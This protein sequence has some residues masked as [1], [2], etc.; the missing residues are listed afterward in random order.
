MTGCGEERAAARTP[1]V[2]RLARYLWPYRIPFAIALVQVLLLSGFEL[3]KPWPLKVVV[4]SVLGSL[5]APLPW[6]DVQRKSLLLVFCC[7]AVVLIQILLAVLLYVNNKTT[8]TIGQRMV[9]DLRSELY[10][11]LQ[12]LSLGFHASRQVGDLMYRLT[13]DTFAIQTITMNGIFPMASAGVFVVGM[14]VILVR[15]DFWLTIVTLAICPV[16]YLFIRR[17]STR[18]RDVSTFAREQESDVYSIVQ[19]GLSAIRVVQAFTRE[20]DEHNRFLQQ[21]R[22]S[23]SAARRLYLVQ[24]LYSGLVSTLIAVGTAV[25]L[26]IGARRVLAATMSVGDVLVFLSYAAALYTP[27]NT[28]SQTFGLIVG[29]TAGIRR[30]FEILDRPEIVQSGDRPVDRAQMRGEIRFEGVTF[31]YDGTRDVLSE[32]SAVIPAGSSVALVGPTG[33]GKTTLVSLLP[34]FVDPKAGRVLLDGVDLREFQLQPLR[35]SISM[36]LQPPIVFPAT[37]RENIAYGRPGAT[38]AEIEE[39]A[40]LAQLRPF[41]D[42]L[43]DGLDARIGE[44]GATISEGERQ[45]LTIA[46]ALLRDAPILILDEP[47]ASV[48][49]ETEA[50]L[51]AGLKRLMRGRT[52]FIIAHRLSTVRDADQILVLREGR[53]VERGNYRSLVKDGGFFARLV[54]L[55]GEEAPLEALGLRSEPLS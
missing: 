44:G 40:R 8:I 55:Q 41:L 29:A 12:R 51:M 47:T 50:L 37:V 31:S 48:D 39:A 22:A 53:I 38:E 52:I 2:R 19:H 18:I 32:I 46:R 43:P 24:T 45:R 10:Q 15:M 35:Q 42:R 14:T 33:A 3:L 49:A 5:P 30:V 17:M 11:H 13:A 20:Q 36:V 34:R 1:L 25:V 9:N 28:V 54:S 26:W 23:L 6:L 7:V 16:L 4:D 21:S 27:V